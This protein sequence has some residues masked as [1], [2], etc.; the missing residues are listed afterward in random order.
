MGNKALDQKTGGKYLF[1]IKLINRLII[2]S[3]HDHRKGWG[4]RRNRALT[5]FH[6]NVSK[7]F[8]GLEHRQ[9]QQGEVA[10]KLQ[11]RKTKHSC[12][13]AWCASLQGEK[14]RNSAQRKKSNIKSEKWHKSRLTERGVQQRKRWRCYRRPAALADAQVLPS[15]PNNPPCCAQK[16]HC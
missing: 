6:S 14:K 8:Y 1:W 12:S 7:S 4:A 5:A 3:F 16:G 15:V 2:S 9:S 11:A 10:H 13:V